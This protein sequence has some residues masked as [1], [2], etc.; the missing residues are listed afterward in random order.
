MTKILTQHIALNNQYNI[1]NSTNLAKDIVKLE[2]TDTHRLI[3]FDI[4][5]L[6]VNIPIQ[7]TINIAQERMT[8]NN[9]PQKTQRIIKLLKVILRQNYFTFQEQIFQPTQGVAMGSPISGLVLEIFLQHEEIHIKHIL[10]SKKIAYYARYV[11]DILIIYDSAQIN[12]KDIDTYINRIHKNIKLNITHEE[13]H[14]INF[15]D[16]T[17]TRNHNKLEINIYRKPTTT[18]TTINFLSN[19]PM[20]HRMA[21]YRHH[22]DRM[23]TLPLDKNKKWK[24]W[25]TIQRIGKSNNVP[26]QV[27]QKLNKRTQQKTR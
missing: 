26:M 19:H 10:D 22:I 23:H 7:E 21:A 12:K 4:K 20:E 14:S 16:L 13:Q 15:L 1:T 24:E 18:D 17:I 6:Y 2:I 3:T 25:Q 9:D 5:D 11:D 27:L 8:K